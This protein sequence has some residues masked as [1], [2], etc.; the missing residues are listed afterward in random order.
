LVSEYYSS[1]MGRFIVPDPAGGRV[2]DPPNP[3]RWN[4]YA[5]AAGD[6]VN[7]S[8]PSGLD[9]RKVSYCDVYPDDPSCWPFYGGP[10]PWG[11]TGGGG[12]PVTPIDLGRQNALIVQNLVSEHKI[13]SDCLGLAAF[14]ADMATYFGDD[15]SKY[16]DSFGALTPSIRGLGAINVKSSSD[17][18]VCIHRT[19]QLG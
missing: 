12:S 10:N 1:F 17:G 4:R 11:R 7:E 2:V 18:D 6:P 14:A 3:A 16:A 5:Y 15:T 8:D 19:K 9:D 13:S